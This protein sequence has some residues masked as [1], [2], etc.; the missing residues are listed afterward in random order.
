M[1]SLQRRVG[2]QKSGIAQAIPAACAHEATAYEFVEGL[3]WGDEPACPRCG[4]LDVAQI[5]DREGNRNARFLWRCHGCK[6]QFTV[7]IG[8]LFEESR[9]PLRIWCHTFW[10]ACSSKKG[11]SA[12]QIHRETG[13]TYK[14]A[15]FLMHRIRFAMAD[16]ETS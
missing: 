8:T 14:S 11:V 16:A 9:I 6:R 15:L 1:A 13:V 3:R 12:L 2:T 5:K 10:R 4:D 7:R